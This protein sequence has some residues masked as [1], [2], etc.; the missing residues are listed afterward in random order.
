MKTKVYTSE[1]P[2]LYARVLQCRAQKTQPH[3]CDKECKEANHCYYHDWKAEVFM[4]GLPTGTKLV[5][6]SGREIQLPPRPLLLTT[7]LTRS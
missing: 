5:L 2:L 6:P 4:Y 3:K 1:M 7:R